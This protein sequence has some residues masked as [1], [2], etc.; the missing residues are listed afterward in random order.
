MRAVY[1]VALWLMPGSVA[2]AQSDPPPTP[3]FDVASIK[4]AAPGGRGMF[5]RP[6]AGGRV[7][8]TNMPL[9]VLIQLAYSIQPFQISGG[10]PWMESIHYDI[11]A[12]P[13]IPTKQTDW[14]VMLRALLA[15]RFQLVL[16]KETKELPIYALVLARKDGKL[17]PG[18]T[19]AQEGACTAFD[20]S[21]PPP[22][23]GRGSSP[24]L[25]CGT[26]FMSPRSI[27]A[28]AV[29]VEN[30]IPMLSRTLGRTVINKTGLDGKYDIKMEYTPDENQLAQMAPPGTPPPS[31]PA[32]S[33]G[34]SLFTALQEQLG[35]KL[36]SQKGP[37][38]IFVIDKAEKPSEN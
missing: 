26:Q 33:S 21:K 9:K 20:P 25:F 32:D 3:K 2:I 7:T 38:E 30:L 8:V 24:T 28:S 16:H 12:K 37:V 6:S 35:L 22:P 36:E 18:M 17:G 10:P 14:P 23:P 15:D 11:E 27:T 31:A 4:P 34:P 5:I 19:A 29:P 1:V 13:D